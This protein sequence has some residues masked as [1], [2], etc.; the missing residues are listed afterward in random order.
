[1]PKDRRQILK[2]PTPNAAQTHK[3]ALSSKLNSCMT[4]VSLLDYMP[5]QW[6]IQECL[7]DMSQYAN[8]TYADKL[9]FTLMI[10]ESH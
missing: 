6:A 7:T 8:V 4:Q 9:V 1:V 10:E 3:R 2:I 5:P